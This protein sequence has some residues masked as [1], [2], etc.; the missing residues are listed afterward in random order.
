MK[1]NNL[2][3]KAKISLLLFGTTLSVC[4]ILG[5]FS[6]KALNFIGNKLYG[7]QAE[8]ILQSTLPGID[9]DKFQ[10]LAKSLN[11]QDEYYEKLRTYLLQIR[12]NVH[13]KYLYTMIKYDNKTYAYVVD[14]GNP[15]D[16]GFSAIGD[17]SEIG[18][19]ENDRTILDALERGKTGFLDLYFEEKWGYALSGYT[20]IRNSKNEIVGALGVDFP[21]DD[22]IKYKNIVI[23]L[24]SGILIVIMTISYLFLNKMLRPLKYIINQIHKMS[25]GNLGVTYNGTSKDEIGKVQTSLNELS[26]RLNA[27]VKDIDIETNGINTTSKQLES[28]ASELSSDSLAQNESFETIV[29][30]ISEINLV[31]SENAKNAETTNHI[32]KN[33]AARSSEGGKAID[34]AINSIK[35]I[36]QKVSQIEDIAYQTNLLALNASVEAARAGKLG[37]GFAVVAAEVKKLSEK[38]RLVTKD[39]KELSNSSIHIGDE[40]RLVVKDIFHEVQKTSGL[41][42]K[43]SVSILQEEERMSSINSNVN[44]LSNRLKVKANVSN[45][46][47]STAHKLNTNALILR[48]LSSFFKYK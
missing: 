9:G 18:N 48:K 26:N 22:F 7:K 28:V 39:I 3:V 27:I 23:I 36:A 25:D 44:S 2:S 4:L 6:Y 30:S 43:I 13:A 40:A 38:T 47:S 24:I 32:A 8:V 5:I 19:S 31:I 45:Q 34:K 1:L 14:G 41:V 42:Q 12:D 16:E 21:A 46:L 35:T 33:V 29:K 10:I 37:A 11:P 17:K 20:P 15:T